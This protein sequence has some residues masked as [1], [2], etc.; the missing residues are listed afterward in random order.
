M[1]MDDVLLMAYVDGELTPRE[2]ENVEKTMSVSPD[3]ARRVACFQASALRYRHAFAHQRLPPVPER[4]AQRVA[5]L[6]RAYGGTQN[7][8]DDVAL[9]STADITPIGALKRNP[10]AGAQH[11]ANAAMQISTRAR[12][13][14]RT[15]FAWP[16]FAWPFLAGAFTCAACG[17][18]VLSLAPGWLPGD[19]AHPVAVATSAP[20]VMPWV[21]A[22]V[23][24]QR[25]YTRD[26]VSSDMPDMTVAAR[27]IE[28]IHSDD[29]VPLRVPD[30][31]AAGLTFKRIQ[32]L[33]FNTKPLVQ[34]VYLPKTGLPVA[35]C[36]MK[37]DRPDTAMKR[38]HV[39]SLNVLTWRRANLSYA[40]IAALDDN[41]LSAIGK[42]IAEGRDD[43]VLGQRSAPPEI[44]AS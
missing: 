12:N 22:A 8:A 31:R 40:L 29:G 16:R 23:N 28:Q 17:A 35:L 14:Q 44:S 15:R 30:L 6:S 33:R 43:E 41:A 26:T 7:G 1:N 4:L 19:G 34:I 18:L 36:V 37:D 3:V 27:V 11:H 24:Y 39:D 9:A 32:R 2:R 38:Q 25:L 42:Q 21:A 5:E 13:A 20:G 10:A